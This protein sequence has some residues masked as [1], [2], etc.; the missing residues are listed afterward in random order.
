M[1]DGVR[2]NTS[3]FTPDGTAVPNGWLTTVLVRGLADSMAAAVA[4][5]ENSP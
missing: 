2:L 1:D 5:S 4:M 3:P